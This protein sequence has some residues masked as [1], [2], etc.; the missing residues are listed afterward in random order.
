MMISRYSITAIALL[1]LALVAG[2]NGDSTTE[3]TP[4]SADDARSG[5]EMTIMNASSAAFSFPAPNLD[6]E[7]FNLHAEGDAAFE[8]TFVTAPASVNAGLGPVYNN[9]SCISCHARDGRGRP[10]YSGENFSSML[11]RISIPGT[12]SDGGPNPVP[13][14]GGQLQNRSVFGVSA[15]GTISTTYI[16]QQGTFADGQSYT[17]RKP[18][19]VVESSYRPTPAG[20][21]ISPRIAPPVVG[22]GL[23]E[24]VPESALLAN[25]DEADH[26][27]DGISGRANYV[28][29]VK[30]GKQ[31]IGRFG[32]KANTPSLLQQAAAAYNNDMGITSTMF[33]LETCHGQPQCD[34]TSDDP[35]VDEQT[36]KAAAHYTATLA[37]PARRNLN[38]PQVQR[39]QVV[40]RAASC[41]RCHVET[42]QTG[43]APN[44]P[45]LSNQ[46]I[47]PYTDLLLH[48][49]G[50]GLA[51]N[52]PD[53]LANGREW[54][55]QP[56]WGIGLTRIV[57]GH[58]FFLHDGRARDLMEA[59]LWHGG[60]AE[61]S[62][63]YVQQLP[64]ADRDALIAFLESL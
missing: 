19:Y 3:P 56:L 52:R 42:L 63:N 59:I 61:A 10:P 8:A 40:F 41:N 49:M 20:M 18:R 21:M 36:L 22:L 2:C 60:E 9:T 55:T 31:A 12:G 39:G 13:G 17:L 30:E 4:P 25:A 43:I 6:G 1:G 5:G 53:Y 46:T 38:N 58:T 28:W 54:R 45:Y 23:L 48:D 32:W 7:A 15:E 27:G 47:H 62:R 37:V 11:F 33:P 44:A 35:E 64:R 26:D 24:A 34:T 57:N 50:E 29:D 14:F 16:E 51:D